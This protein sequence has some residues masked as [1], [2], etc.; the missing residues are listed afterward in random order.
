MEQWSY[1]YYKGIVTSIVAEVPKRVV[2]SLRVTIEPLKMMDGQTATYIN[3][4][5]P[6][7]L[8]SNGITVGSEVY[9]ERASD[10]ISNLLYG[11]RLH[12]VLK[13]VT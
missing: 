3:V 8:I 1:K 4:F 11:E 13:G 10:A 7:I 12:K 5:N 6:D 2:G 9:F